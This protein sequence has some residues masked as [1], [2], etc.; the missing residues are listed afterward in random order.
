VFYVNLPIGAL[1]ILGML[2]FLPR[3]DTDSKLTFD[4]TGFAGLALGIA[5]LQL[6]L[7]RGETKDW[8]SSPEIMVEATLS[9]I[10]FYIFGVQ[11][12]LG[13]RPFITASIFRDRN[14][15]TCLGIQLVV[16]MILNATSALLPPFFQTLG[17]Y[18]VLLSGLAMAPRGLGTIVASPLVGRV[19]NIV[20]PRVLMLSGLAVLGYA[21]WEMTTWTPD[22]SIALQMPMVLLQGVT[23]SLVFAPLQSVAFT[24]LPAHLRTECSGIIALFR[25]LGGSVGVSIMETL[26]ARNTQQAHSD[27][28][29]FATP[30]NRALQHGAAAQAW[31]PATPQ[32]AAALDGMVNYYAQIVAYRDVFLAMLIGMAPAVVLILLMRRTARVPVLPEELH[33]AVD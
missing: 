11:M 19:I 2:A 33:A 26:L 10:G 30:F 6:M 3:S 27:L 17:N 15:V 32:G 9:A 25:N 24:T 18:P 14:F 7:D 13:K 28:A 4:W 21:T 1:G 20:D 5:G 8:F 22:T 16:G 12:V 23:I 29:R 31:N